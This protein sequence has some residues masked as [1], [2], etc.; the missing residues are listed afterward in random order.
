[1]TRLNSVTTKKTFIVSG[2]IVSILRL[3]VLV[4]KAAIT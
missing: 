2:G 4:M 1:M 3:T